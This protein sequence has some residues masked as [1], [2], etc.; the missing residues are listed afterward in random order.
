LDHPHLARVL[1]SLLCG[2]Q[3]LATLAI[4]LNRT[5]ATNPLWT[6]HARFHVVWQSANMALLA[7]V[8]LMILWLPGS[9]QS[10]SFYLVLL[11]TAVSPFGFVIALVCRKLF[12][13]NLSDPNGIPPFPLTLFSEKRSIDLNCV[14]VIAALVSIIVIFKLY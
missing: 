11:L 3:G 1:L 5:H 2:T 10:K 8:E 9:F 7:V 6:G 4:D 13:G 12:G 14:A